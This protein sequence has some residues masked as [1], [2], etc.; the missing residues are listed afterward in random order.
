M[1]RLVLSNAAL[2]E[3]VG[4]WVLFQLIDEGRLRAISFD[5]AMNGTLNINAPDPR[6]SQAPYGFPL[7]VGPTMFSFG[8]A[9]GAAPWPAHQFTWSNDGRFMCA[10]TPEHPVT[11]APL[12]LETAFVGQQ[13]KLVASGFGTYSDNASFP[14]LACDDESDLA[15]VVANGQGLFSSR[16]WIFRLSTGAL[17]RS[18]TYPTDA[19]VGRWVVA[20][21]DAT[22]LAESVQGPPD[23]G[24]H[25]SITRTA[26]GTALGTLDG[27]VIRGFSGD[28]ALVVAEGR[29]TSPSANV[30]VVSAIDWRTKR[31]IWSADG[32][33]GGYVPEPA[34]TRLAIG[35]G[36]VGGT[37]RDLYLV[38][39]SGRSVLLPTIG[40]FS[41]RG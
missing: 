24:T 9:I 26:D 16:V 33:Y 3:V 14:V 29:R 40:F 22:M 8:Q 20:S 21:P 4:K 5:G 15:V 13:P 1:Q 18:I 7:V 12:R 10:V 38:E 41:P 34:G 27:A 37:Q 23:S 17:L 25:A 32:V 35:V 31:V 11:G 39:S 6:W 28:G 2:P 36:F 19:V 30:A